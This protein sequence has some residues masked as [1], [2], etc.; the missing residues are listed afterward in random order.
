[1]KFMSM[2]MVGSL[3]LGTSVAPALARDHHNH[4]ARN[5][6]V[7]HR[8]QNRQWQSGNR[9]SIYRGQ[10]GAH[11]YNGGWSGNR[12][13]S[14]QNRAYVQQTGSAQSRAFNQQRAANY[15][16][17][18]Q[19]AALIEQQRQ[20]NQNALQNPYLYQNYRGY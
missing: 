19:Q 7:H 18:Q 9:G 6:Q 16:G 15:V 2:L 1:M 4:G 12:G 13:R 8:S 20:Q 17:Q 5:S 14:G 10:Y 11:N 3:I